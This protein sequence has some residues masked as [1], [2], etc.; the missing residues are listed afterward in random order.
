MKNVDKKEIA[1]RV[2]SGL[3]IFLTVVVFALLRR[4]DGDPTLKMLTTILVIFLLVALNTAIIFLYELY[5]SK[6][7]KE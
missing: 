7:S 2:F 5:K 4:L 3:C 1:F 6:N